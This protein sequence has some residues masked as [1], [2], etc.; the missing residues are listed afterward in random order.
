M[1]M[2]KITVYIPEDIQ[3]IGITIHHESE[4]PTRSPALWWEV[5]EPHDEAHRIVVGCDE[6][7]L[8]DD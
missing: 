5:H 2:K 7:E 8:D 6:G 3:K 1:T 4:S